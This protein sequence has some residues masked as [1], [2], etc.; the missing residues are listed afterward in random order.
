MNTDTHN[1]LPDDRLLRLHYDIN[2]KLLDPGRD[3]SAKLQDVAHM[4]ADFFSAKKC[5][6][7]MI[8]NQDM[9]LD[10]A[11]STNP[12]IIGLKRNLADVTISTRALLDN[13]PFRADGK[14]RSFFSPLEKSMYDS[15]YSISIP[16]RYFD[17]KIGVVNMTDFREG[18]ELT[19]EQEEQA[20]SIVTMTAPL[21][22]AEHTTR[23]L[24][25]KISR[26][27][28]TN[29]KILELD[30]MKTALTHF[31]VHDLKGP[32]ATV[33]A[34]LDMLS[35]EEL[36]PEQFEYLNLATEDIFK[37]QRM[38]MNILDVLKLEEGRI[39]IY[40]EECDINEIAERETKSVKSL[41]ARRNMSIDVTGSSYS[42]YI[43]ENLI[44]RT[45]SNL[46]INAIEHTKDGSAIKVETGYN[47]QAKEVIVKV[48]DN[49]PGIPDDMKEKIFDKYFQIKENNKQR[50]ATTGLG[51]NFCKLVV[52]AHGGR[53][54]VENAP[55]GGSVFIFTLPEK[56][57]EMEL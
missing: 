1:T 42:C 11:A 39:A 12:A 34:N 3:H 44:G 41:V 24:E 53:L 16:I 7:M 6:I 4:I 14:R 52:E 18:L 43:D 25:S 27:E 21:L 51:L 15:E 55:G 32:I 23:L 36:T 45:I 2:T 13:E 38:V 19:P 46:L 35:Y 9:T 26:L 57:K 50:K 28:E 29:K 56:P 54:Y 40:R 48:T 49:G 33:T 10:V 20:V 30:E 8:N 17:K 5:S 37:M 31:I 22:Y 47:D